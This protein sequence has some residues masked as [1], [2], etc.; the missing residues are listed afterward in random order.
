MTKHAAPRLPT[1]VFSHSTTSR[2]IGEAS[3]VVLSV[4]M[5][6]PD[7]WRARSTR[8]DAMNHNYMSREPFHVI[9]D[10]WLHLEALSHHVT[11]DRE[12]ALRLLTSLGAPGESG[13]C[14][15]RTFV[16]GDPNVG[17]VER[18]ERVLR[19]LETGW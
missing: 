2:K 8:R 4:F 9:K 18:V 3:D 5:P 17:E 6:T 1:Y 15:L 19:H 10:E 14:R 13:A 16:H 11:P 7:G 12:E